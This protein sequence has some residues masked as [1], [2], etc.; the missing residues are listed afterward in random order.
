MDK[1]QLHQKFEELYTKKLEPKIIPLEQ[2]RKSIAKVSNIN[3]LI[4][5]LCL[6]GS[7][8]GFLLLSKAYILL[9]LIPAVI[10]FV[11]ENKR[12]RKFRL[13]LKQQLLMELFSLF[14]KFM[15]CPDKELITRNEIRKT[16]LFPKFNHKRDDDRIVGNYKGMDI[17]IVE[18]ELTH[19]ESGGE[20]NSDSTVTD[21]N[22]LI[23]KT[24]LN[25]PY[26]GKTLLYQ[27][28]IG[29]K[30]Q[31]QAI[32]SLL[33]D[34]L[35]DEQADKIA[36]SDVVNAVTG[37]L[38][39]AEKLPLKHLKLSEN[40]VSLSLNNKNKEIRVAGNLQKVTLEDSEFNQMYDIYSDDQVEARYILTP[41]FMERL[42]NVREVIGGFD[43]HC[44]IENKY[45][46]LFIQTPN[47][48]FEIGN[49]ITDS[50][51]NKRNYEC[52]FVQLIN[53]FNL[54]HYFKLDKKLGL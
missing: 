9:F 52:I 23:I 51:N 54:I 12:Q 48:F 45:I 1:N 43:V 2:E 4:A 3:L 36:N 8:G 24:T 15:Y 50:I 17:I 28:V 7:I 30:G 25:K 44:L 22:G 39:F 37:V 34:S 14:G 6:I 27:K 49:N 21:F 41:T 33:S 5:V 13:K 11:I 32:K 40:G 42:K 35:G 26:K 18:T 29:Q 46:T 20:G 47:D 31:K 16:G 10:M 38:A 19:T 53:I